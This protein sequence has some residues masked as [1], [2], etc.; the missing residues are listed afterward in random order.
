MKDHSPTT[1]RMRMVKPKRG[2]VEAD[3]RGLGKCGKPAAF[4]VGRWLIETP[5]ILRKGD[6]ALN[7]RKPTRPCYAAMRAHL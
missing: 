3:H 7:A 6:T 5:R 4:C 2:K 1:E